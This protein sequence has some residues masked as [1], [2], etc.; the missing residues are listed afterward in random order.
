MDPWLLLPKSCSPLLSAWPPGVTG[1][2][3][4][5]CLSTSHSQSRLPVLHRPGVERIKPS[6]PSFKVLG[7]VWRGPDPGTCSFSGVHL[8]TLVLGSQLSAVTRAPSSIKGRLRG[9]GLQGLL[10][11]PFISAPRASE[12]RNSALPQPKLGHGARSH[13]P[14]PGA[15]GTTFLSWPGLHGCFIILESS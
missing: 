3:L 12:T 13:P 11:A 9:S 14:P 4:S 8:V 1:C 10:T 7:T 6:N 5:L 2:L 15:R